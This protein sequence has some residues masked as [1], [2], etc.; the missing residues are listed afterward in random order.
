MSNVYDIPESGY[1][2]LKDKV[3]KLSKKIEKLGGER[4]IMTVVGKHFEGQKDKAVAD[5]TKRKILEVL[6][7][8]PEIK[9]SGWSF[10]ARLDH[11]QETG[12]LIRRISTVGIPTH[13]RTATQVCDHC[14]IKR[15]RRDTFVVYHAGNNE[16][17]QV[18]SSCISDFLGHEDGD[19]LAKLAC[20]I[21]N[22][23]NLIHFAQ[24]HRENGVDRRYIDVE[25]YC[26]SAAEVVLKR[27]WLSKS[28]ARNR[29]EI[30]TASFTDEHYL[31]GEEVSQTAKDLARDALAWASVIGD[32]GSHV[33]DFQHNIKV[34]ANSDCMEH[35][36]GPIAAALVGVYYTKTLNR[37]ATKPSE[38]QG[39]VGAFITRGMRVAKIIPSRFNKCVHLRDDENNL[40]V[41]FKD[42]DADLIGQRITVKGRVKEHKS[43]NGTHETILQAV[44]IIY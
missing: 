24:S 12:T 44:S 8:V 43:F 15:Y 7:D 35:R 5:R 2:W 26:Q 41:F 20:Q 42:L 30:S 11:S 17:K 25:A 6:L 14:Q 19:R 29:N 27:K 16:F 10:A 32:D 40:F 1:E 18:G 13:Y 36:A 9:Y 22:L 31:S 23:T 4:I 33:N 34:I 3:A 38:P 21:S 28:D 39:E 37:V